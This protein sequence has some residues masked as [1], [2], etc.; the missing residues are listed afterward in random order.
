[1][2]EMHMRYESI[3]EKKDILINALI[4]QNKEL[5]DRLNFN[6]TNNQINNNPPKSI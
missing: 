1:M 4:K 3:I 2:N 6:K 5:K